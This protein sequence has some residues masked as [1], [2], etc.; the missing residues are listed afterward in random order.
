MATRINPTAKDLY[1]A[2]FYVWAQN[3]A[4]LLRDRRFDELDLANLIEEVEDLG[5]AH[6][7]SAR[8]HVMTISEHLLKL[9]YW[10]Q[11]EQ[12]LAWREAVR[13]ER[14][15]LEFD[16]TPTLRRELANEVPELYARARHDA[17]GSLE[18]HGERDAAAAL[19]ATCPLC[20]RSDRRRL[21]AMNEPAL[22]RMSPQ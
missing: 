3:Q 15:E 20:L 18:D 17:E 7:R 4:E 14:S 16:L 10:P 8:L 19:P 6:R 1:Q 13:R 2:D 12:W 22:C 5:G 9:Q 21:A 11:S